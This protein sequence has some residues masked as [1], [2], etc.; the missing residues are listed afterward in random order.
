[1]EFD[2]DKITKLAS[3]VYN[4]LDRLR[5]LAEL[6]EGNFISDRYKVAGSKYFLIVAIEG[7]IDICNHL[8]SRN[9]FRMP[10]DYDDTFR[11]M[12]EEKILDMNFAEKLIEMA[13]FR[14]RLVH[15]YWEVNDSIIYTIMREDVDDIAQLME[16]LTSAMNQS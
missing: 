6:E 3:E 1:M 5:E 7:T 10:E 16:K 13:K 9:R 11:V 8:I 12:A 4:A 15:I 2:I 14:N